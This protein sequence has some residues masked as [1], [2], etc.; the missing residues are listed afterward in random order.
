M[1]TS[2]RILSLAVLLALHGTANATDAGIVVGRANVQIQSNKTAT[3]TSV[4]DAFVARDTIIDADGTEHVRFDRTYKGLPVIGGDLVVHSKNGYFGGASLTMSQTLNLATTPK[5]SSDEALTIA[6]SDFGTGFTGLPTTRLVVFARGG[7]TARLA[8]EAVFAG[9]RADRTPTRMHYFVDA[10]SS[11]I[12]A[13]WDGV[14]TGVL[15]GGGGVLTPTIG[16]GRS[17]LVGTVPLNT[18]LDD[19]HLYELKDSTRGG[20]RT[21]D[22]GNSYRGTGIQVVDGDDVFG[23]FTRSDRA[24]VAV[25]AQYGVAKTWDFYK[26]NFGR[27]GVAN[28]GVGT[29]NRVHYLTGYVNAFWLD[30]CF[31]M[32]FGDGDGVDF[33]PVVA[34]DVTGHEMSHGVTSHSANLDYFGASG[35][36]NEAT[37]DIM[38]TMVEFYANNSAS[39]PNYVIGER[40]Y[41]NNPGN[42]IGLRYMFKP[43][44]DGISP[45]CYPVRDPNPDGYEYFFNNYMDVHYNSGV[46]NHFF[47]LLAEGA[48]VP[49]GYGLT[50]ADLVCNGNTALHGIGRSAAQRIWYRAL[51]VYMTSSSNYDGARAATLSA[52]SDLFGANSPQRNAVLAAWAAVNLN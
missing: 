5:I 23:N 44:L 11:R 28:N 45:D 51:T 34:L 9:E 2:Y 6:G 48:A 52:A 24:S 13:K 40:V 10:L 7:A 22:L 3:H 42:L 37:S 17:L 50:A 21:I 39:P 41:R 27:L 32:T 20:L 47:Y 43:Y 26:N 30:E 18:V 4:F 19:R 25:D 1:S 29:Q 16:S 35:G 49:A 31:C 36:L 15:P 33:N 38:G 14:E 8:Y 12:L 46:A